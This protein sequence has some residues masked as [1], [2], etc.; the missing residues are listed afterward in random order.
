MQTVKAKELRNMENN[1]IN[2][3]VRQAL[4][5]S[6]LKQLHFIPVNLQKITTLNVNKI[7]RILVLMPVKKLR[8]AAS[9]SVRQQVW[10]NRQVFLPSTVN[11]DFTWTSITIKNSQWQN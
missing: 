2:F 7:S 10:A 6:L 8:D 3:I 1:V 4:Q 9:L 5:A 11:L